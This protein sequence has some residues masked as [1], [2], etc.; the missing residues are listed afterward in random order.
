[1]GGGG[2]VLSSRLGGRKS[3]SSNG[4]GLGRDDSLG[5]S[6]LQQRL[7]F[8]GTRDTVLTQRNAIRS[9]SEAR[10]SKAKHD[11]LLSLCFRYENCFQLSRANTPD[12]GVFVF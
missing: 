2:A 12:R 9:R 10:K 1:M 8:Q 11:G 4:A 7:A 3:T 6:C 5:G